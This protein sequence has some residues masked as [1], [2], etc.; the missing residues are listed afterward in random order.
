MQYKKPGSM[1]P[2]F[3]VDAPT[4]GSIG[5]FINHTSVALANCALGAL[6]LHRRRVMSFRATKHIAPGEPIRFKY[7]GANSNIADSADGRCRAN[8][9]AY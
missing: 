2:L 1:E 4:W 3:V 8:T 9:F 7:F 5:R 6:Q